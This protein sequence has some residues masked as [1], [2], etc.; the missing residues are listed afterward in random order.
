M[1]GHTNFK[2]VV[3]LFITILCFID[4]DKGSF[5]HE[6]PFGYSNEWSSNALSKYGLIACVIKIF[7]KK[8]TG[9]L[10]QLS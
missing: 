7:D 1:R 8:I 10:P 6:V 4:N 9:D 5:G 3:L 2:R